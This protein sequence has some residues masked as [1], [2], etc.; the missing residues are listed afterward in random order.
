[1]KIEGN[2][3]IS[4]LPGAQRLERRFAPKQYDQTWLVETE[5]QFFSR[6]AIFYST[7]ARQIEGNRAS[8]FEEKYFTKMQIYQDPVEGF[9]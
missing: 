2:Q 1:M 8:G 6:Q 9:C 4:A 7:T 5:I 3:K